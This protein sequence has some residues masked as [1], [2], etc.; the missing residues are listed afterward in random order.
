MRGGDPSTPSNPYPLH[1]VPPRFSS[2]L[3]TRAFRRTFSSSWTFP[4]V[5]FVGAPMPRRSASSTLCV[6][7]VTCTL[8][9][10]SSTS[11][12]LLTRPQ[13]KLPW[14]VRLHDV[15]DSGRLWHLLANFLRGTMSQV[16]IGEAE[17][18]LHLID[19]LVDSLATTLRASVP[20]VRLVDSDPFRH[21][22]KLF[23]DDLVTLANSQAD[24][25]ATRACFGLEFIGDDSSA[26][27]QFNLGLHR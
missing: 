20:G 23:A 18:S 8:L 3:S 14:S 2:T 5:V 25:Q 11:R 6:S 26:L 9:L 16:R 19:L 4:K 12:K 24:L 13:S 7:G 22:C 17:F 21:V 1:H 10:H 15:G 27:H